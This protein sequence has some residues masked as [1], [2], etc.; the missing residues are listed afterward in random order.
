[1]PDLPFFHTGF[2]LGLAVLALVLFTIDRLRLETS[3][4]IILVGLL[5]MFSVVP[6]TI[7]GG[8]PFRAA[9]LLSAFSNEALIAVCA[10]MVLGKGIETTR[11]LQPLVSYVSRYW[12]LS[13]AL[14]MLAVLVVAAFLSAF[15]NNTP[16]VIV[17]L[18]ALIAIAKKNRLSPASMLMPVGLVTIIGGMATT[19]GTSTNLLVVSMSETIASVNFDMF[20]FAGYV[21]IAGAAGVIY[22]WLVAPRIMRDIDPSAVAETRREFIA[23]MHIEPDSPLVGNT[24]SEFLERSGRE[25]SIDRIQ[26]GDEVFHVP[27]PTVILQ[28]NDRVFVRGTRENLKDAEHILK[29]PL[30]KLA[31]DELDNPEHEPTLA[32]VLITDRSE[33]DGSTIER[34]QL[35]ER[36]GILP[37]ALHRPNPVRRRAKR[38]L[39]RIELRSGDILLCEGT[40][41][42]FE[43]L[44]S[45]TRLFI[46]SELTDLPLTSRAPLAAGIMIGVV[47]F[48][49]LGLLPI[50]LAALVGVALM[51]ATRCLGWRH[52]AE[53]LSADVVMIIV[54]SLALGQALIVT[55]GDVYLAGIFNYLTANLAPATSL[56][57]LMLFM[58]VLTNI[59]SNNAAAVI[60]TPVA[61][62][63]AVQ[64][65]VAPE[66]FILAVLFGANLEFRHA[67][68]LPDQ[69]TG[70][71]R[72]RL[73]LQRF[74]P[75]R[76]AFSADHVGL[77]V[78]DAGERLR[79][80]SAPRFT[81]TR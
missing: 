17:L 27:L 75:H 3:A 63:I 44:T 73:S 59:V 67:H 77:A 18:P 16:I 81:T 14:M 52:V 28:A 35:F 80:V 50:A 74:R 68:R 10:L 51:I 41:Q 20:D 46:S 9:N 79:P 64:I 54:V 58:C 61:V 7:G 2:V 36:Y 33:L 34:F 21:V 40:R 1:M 8:P 56:A 32:E 49:A 57:A 42:Q 22:L 72:R 6:F 66:P 26:H 37:V 53:A 38:S 70:H 45:N 43:D 31:L 47:G 24:V 30:G 11:A 76:R 65:G 13:P 29:A 62:Q 19:I 12:S 78:V 69:L 4:L 5:V 23:T 71:D 15:L 55:S 39:E 25:L 48:A 60:G